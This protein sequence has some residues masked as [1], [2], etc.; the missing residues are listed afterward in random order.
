MEVNNWETCANSKVKSVL[1][2]DSTKFMSKFPS[3]LEFLME[4]RF[5]EGASTIS[6]NFRPYLHQ[7]LKYIGKGT[8]CTFYAIIQ[9]KCS[10][11]N[12]ITNIKVSWQ[13]F[14]KRPVIT[15]KTMLIVVLLV[16]YASDVS[17]LYLFISTH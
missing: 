5:L 3:F 1:S 13:A 9:I 15:L 14:W 2:M 16:L 4:F 10:Y 6:L 8:T 17:Q 11:W 7:I 12:C